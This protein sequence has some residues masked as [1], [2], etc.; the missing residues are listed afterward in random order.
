MQHGEVV[1]RPSLD[2]VRDGAKRWKTT[3][4][5][6]LLGKRPYYHHL[7]EY[8]HSVWPDLREVTAI[9]NGFFFF[10]FKNVIAMEEV[11]EGGPWLFQG[12]P[13][14]LQKWETGMAMRKQK[15][16][17][18]PVWIKLR[19]LPMEYWTTEGLSTV[20][21]GVDCAM[22]K[23]LKSTKPPVAVYVPKAIVPKPQLATERKASNNVKTGAG[24]SRNEE[25]NKH[26]KRTTIVR[27][28]GTSGK[29]WTAC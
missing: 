4:V 11:I 6:Y 14:V 5:G 17:Q 7:K 28:H 16:T 12:Q 22:N 1:V 18:I 15:H 8:A 24:A 29:D 26:M 20:A 10:Q 9:A 13:I 21:S 27:H 25:N 19:H 3:T 2:T 23:P